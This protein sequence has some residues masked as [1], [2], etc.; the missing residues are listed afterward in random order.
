VTALA[1]VPAWRGWVRRHERILAALWL[2]AVAV[3]LLG[4]AVPRSRDA[5]LYRVQSLSDRWDARWDSRLTRG[6][7]LVAAGRDTAAVAYLERLDGVFPARNARHARD[8]QREHLL[9]LLARGYEA[10]GKTGRAM[11][12]YDRLVAFD[13]LNYYNHY[14]RATAAERLLSG[15]AIAPEAR[16]GFA[17]ALQ[18]NPNHLPS[19]RG[20]IRYFSDRSDWH[21]VVEAFHAYLDAFLVQAVSVRAGADTVSVM[22]PVDGRTHTVSLLLHGAAD[23]AAIHANGFAFAVDTVTVTAPARVGAAQAARATVL[24]S[25][26]VRGF[27]PASNGAVRPTAEGGALTYPLPRASDG[28]SVRFTVRLFKPV[29]ATLWTTVAMSHRNILDHDGIPADASRCVVFPDAASADA[30]MDH[31]PSARD[32]LPP[33]AVTP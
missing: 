6:D 21:P 23:S 7:S 5:A 27:D 15:W 19:V 8:K 28:A 4:L 25:P 3:L 18:L 9:D 13:S 24:G 11:A 29:D 30:V 14:L 22:V 16:D 10:L 31:L 2:A 1:P 33:A 12:T 20:Y 26:S 17:G 32:G